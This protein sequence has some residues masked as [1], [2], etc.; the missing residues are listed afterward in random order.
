VSTRGVLDF[1][2]T[3]LLQGGD[4][5][6]QLV[7]A[8]EEPDRVWNAVTGWSR[9][10]LTAALVAAIGVIQGDGPDERAAGRGDHL[11]A[12]GHRPAGRVTATA[13]VRTPPNG[14]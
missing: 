2:V 7:T 1:T 4:D 9:H 11:C 12:L 13:A 6:V 3:D 5:V 8:G 14:R 10:R